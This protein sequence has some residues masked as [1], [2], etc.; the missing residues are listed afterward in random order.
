MT[1]YLVAALAGMVCVTFGIRLSFLVFGHRLAFPT[2]LER[3]LRYVPVAVLTALI[4]PMSV[5]PHGSI[6]FSSGNAYLP[7]ALAAA[8]VAFF[9]KHTLLAIVSGFL[10][11]GLWRWVHR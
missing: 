10:V 6:D 11:Y 1:T 9:S 8:M 3:A 2:W 7:G 5:A 4:V